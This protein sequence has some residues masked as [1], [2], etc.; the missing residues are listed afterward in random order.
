MMLILK[1][2]TKAKEE[3]L[4]ISKQKLK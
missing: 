4:V 2:E 1:E 3:E